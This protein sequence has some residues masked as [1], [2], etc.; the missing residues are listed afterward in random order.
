[1]VIKRK[2]FVGIEGEGRLARRS[3][4]FEKLLGKIKK[5]CIKKVKVI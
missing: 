1:M 5:N 2:C 3:K 4:Y